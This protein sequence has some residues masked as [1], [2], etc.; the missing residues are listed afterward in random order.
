M[1]PSNAVRMDGIAFRGDRYQIASPYVPPHV[2][3][4]VVSIKTAGI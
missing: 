2:D 4:A 3:C 1:E